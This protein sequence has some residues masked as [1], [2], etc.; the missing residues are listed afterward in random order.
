MSK[1]EKVW[2]SNDLREK[3]LDTQRSVGVVTELVDAV[4]RHTLAA[5]TSQVALTT[6]VNEFKN[7][8]KKFTK[9]AKA[10]VKNQKKGKT[11]TLGEIAKKITGNLFHKDG[12]EQKGKEG[13]L[14]KQPS[15]PVA[16]ENN[17]APPSYDQRV[18]ANVT[19][20]ELTK[21]KEEWAVRVVQERNEA[22]RLRDLQTSLYSQRRT[23]CNWNENDRRKGK[24]SY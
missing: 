1:S 3:A 7:K 10:L 11:G 15:A 19:D 6:E 14:R 8:H 24:N 2:D 21:G 5:K 22:K 16:D 13:E 4:H 9:C 23:Q 18:E 12:Q 17:E 20:A